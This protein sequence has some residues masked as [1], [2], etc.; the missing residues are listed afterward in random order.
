MIENEPE[1]Q[2]EKK[3]TVGFH[4]DGGSGAEHL[5]CDYYYGTP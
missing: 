2:R 1:K 5:P 3:E 4:G